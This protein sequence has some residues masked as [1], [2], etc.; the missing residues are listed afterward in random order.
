MRMLNGDKNRFSSAAMAEIF[1]YRRAAKSLPP[2]AVET[3]FFLESS[4]R[5]VI[6]YDTP[7]RLGLA[8]DQRENARRFLALQLQV[9]TAADQGMVIAKELNR[10]FVERELAHL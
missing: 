10:Q 7:S 9:E 5:C 6:V 4:T 8:Q 1:S 2:V 3:I